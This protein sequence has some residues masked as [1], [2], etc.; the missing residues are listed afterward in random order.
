MVPITIRQ[1]LSSPL[2]ARRIHITYT[3]E[4]S[5]AERWLRVH[6]LDCSVPAVGFDIEWKPQFVSKKDGGTENE[7]AVLQLA[8]EASCLVLH[9]CHMT[10]LPRSL[11]LLLSDENIVKVGSG[12]VQDG[13]K[14][15]R[16]TELVMRNLDDIQR[17][18][19]I[20]CPGLQKTG[21]KALARHLFGIEID[22]SGAISDCEE[23]PLEPSQIEYAALGAWFGLK[24]FQEL[25]KRQLRSQGECIDTTVN[26]QETQTKTLDKC[27]MI[28]IAFSICFLGIL[29][30]FLFSYS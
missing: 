24:I 3:T 29:S 7:T 9:I 15:E 16:D 10:T 28:C 19:K 2:P 26:D 30:S 11:A 12:I 22:K 4:V 23:I 25:K 13:L 20:L 27:T 21:I 1:E 18:A 14:L 8:V 17:M 6:I 5:E